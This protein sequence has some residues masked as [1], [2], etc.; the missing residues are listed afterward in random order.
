[1]NANQGMPARGIFFRKIDIPIGEVVQRGWDLAM[2][3]LGSFIGYTLVVLVIHLGLAAIPILGWIASWIIN[4]A[5][6]AGYFTYIRKRIRNEPAVFQDFF[7]GF[8]YLGPLFMVGLVGGILVAIGTLLCII[9]GLYLAL[10]YIFASFIVVS[11]RLDFWQAMETSRRAV[12]ENLVTMILFALVMIGI[13]ILGALACL[14]GLIISLP[15]SY[16]AAVV[17]FYMLFEEQPVVPPP[18]P[19]PA[20]GPVHID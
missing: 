11:F 19:P 7:E 20:V 17:A 13:N 10:G 15:V 16:C 18:V 9:P 2:Q 6:S 3:N 12:T 1:M 4:P 8:Q 14:V 5:L